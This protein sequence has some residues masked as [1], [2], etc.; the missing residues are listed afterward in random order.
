MMD[1]VLIRDPDTGETFVR[2]NNDQPIDVIRVPN[3]GDNA[4]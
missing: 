3:G 4:Q 1:R 2:R